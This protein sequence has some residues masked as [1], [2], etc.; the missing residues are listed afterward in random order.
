MSKYL[1]LNIFLIFSLAANAQQE[2]TLPMLQDIPN[3]IRLNPAYKTDYK[4]TISLPST[5]NSAASTGPTFNQI[6]EDN[7]NGSYTLHVA[8]AVAKLQA[9]NVITNTNRLEIFGLSFQNKKSLF[10][11][12]IGVRTAIGVDIPKGLAELA[13]FG[14]GPY[15]GQ[16]LNVGPGLDIQAFTEVGLGYARQFGKLRIGAT[17][18]VLNGIASAKT[19]QKAISLYT[20]SEYYQL[21]A[22]TD[23][24]VQSSSFISMDSLDNINISFDELD[25]KIVA[26]NHGTA[27]DIGVVYDISD[28]FSISASAID[29][30][31]ISW[32]ENA[33]TLHSKGSFT[34]DGIA[35][36]GGLSSI[37]SSSL[38]SFVD[39][40]QKVFNF[41]QKAGEFTTPLAQKF[42]LGAQ[43]KFGEKTTLSAM[44]DATSIL[45]QMRPAFALGAR[46][47]VTNWLGLGGIV[48]YK[49]SEIDHLGL[50]ATF[51]LGPVQLYLLSDN[52]LS[53]LF[54]T[55][56]NDIHFRAGLNLVFGKLNR[57]PDGNK[58][59]APH[60]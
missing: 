11:F 16:T 55:N 2:L 21:T 3:S 39:S 12:N 49:N 48:S 53:Y 17:V 41:S 8:Q 6:F 15:V 52:A 9:N 46:T 60:L 20:D 29:L 32:T 36:N 33:Q 25:P 28:K 45:D 43:Y 23:Y 22:T 18:K 31:R 14:N 1:L 58:L 5:S 37:D 59:L 50:N 38:T 40:I 24:Q 27:F 10:H 51:K 19:T 44:L 13:A 4:W 56:A 47:Y 54:P 30:G 7:G 57:N 35:A 26:G 34:Y 42:T